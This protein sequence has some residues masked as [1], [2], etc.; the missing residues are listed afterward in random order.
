MKTIEYLAVTILS[1]A[2][3]A[4]VATT[5]INAVKTSFDRAN[6]ALIQANQR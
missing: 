2:F 6:A 1:L 5:A 3:A 4:W